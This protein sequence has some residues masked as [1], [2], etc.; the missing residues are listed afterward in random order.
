MIRTFS[1]LAVCAI[2]LCGCFVF[3]NPVESGGSTSA[4]TPTPTVTF[5]VVVASDSGY[6]GTYVWNPTSNAYETMLGG[7]TGSVYMDSYGIWRL[8]ASGPFAQ[9]FPTFAALPPT[10]GASWTTGVTSVDDSAGGISA[11]G[12]PPDAP[13]SRTQT[14]QVSFLASNPQNGATFQWTSSSAVTGTAETVL[15]SAR[16]LQ[17]TS[18]DFQ[19]WIR[20]II[21]PTDSTGTIKGTPVVSPP[22]KVSL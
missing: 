20:V 12:F 4:P 3:D 16:T 6:G 14:L 10:A 8:S 11:V 7:T 2:C 15:G 9:A 21:T 22:V 13:I 18:A 5:Q 17:L 1:L 19:T